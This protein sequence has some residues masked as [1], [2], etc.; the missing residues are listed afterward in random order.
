MRKLYP[1][2][3]SCLFVVSGC[4][5]THFIHVNS[6]SD[7]NNPVPNNAHIFVEVEPNAV[8]PVFSNEVRTKIEKLLLKNNYEVVPVPD[9]AEYHLS[10]QFGS[11]PHGE[12]DYQNTD[13]YFR[14]Q[15]AYTDEAYLSHIELVW[16]QRI[17]MKLY[18]ADKVVWAGEAETMELYVDN[19]KIADYLLLGV[20]EFF[21]HSTRGEQQMT[22]R[23]DDPRIAALNSYAK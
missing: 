23:E 20:F 5:D 18:H 21:G 6:F 11:G 14:R 2:L 1:V 4:A 19:R 22:I 16:D 9:A 3:V 17:R 8:N 12:A 13:E 10:Y 15:G 7:E